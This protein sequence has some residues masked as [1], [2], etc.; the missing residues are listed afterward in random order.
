MEP[1][2]LLAQLRSLLERTPDFD[3]YEGTSREHQTW[4]A[5]AYALVSRWDKVEGMSI[6]VNVGFLDGDLLR[7][8]YV[9]QIL[10]GIYRAIADLELTVPAKEQEN[11]AA[12]NVYDF[13]R[14]LN[15]V[16]S[17]AEKSL[18]IV[19]P[20][21]DVSVFDHYLVSRQSGVSVKLLSDK[22]AE[23]LIPAMQKYNLQFKDVVE[24][25]KSNLIHDRVIFVDNYVC[26][27]LG[28]SVKDA[29]KAKPTY[30]VPAPPDI[31][32]EKLATYD[33]IW[34]RSV[35]L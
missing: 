34:T 5:Q 29:A 20:Y 2:I 32:P 19:D 15:K 7:D 4:L 27:L 13:F 25:R 22:K 9:S 28:Q 8:N 24:L 18:F 10:G 30:L 21:L 35:P 26:W 11:F 23:D 16:I 33:E 12:G 14:A 1:H 17:S 31:V 6:K 3:S